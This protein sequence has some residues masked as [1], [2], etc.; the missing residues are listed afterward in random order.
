MLVLSRQIGEQIYIGDDVIV[1][2]IDIRGDKARIGVEAPKDIPVHRR[3]IAERISRER[4][5]RDD[6]CN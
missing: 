5:E 2:L 1:T 6:A 4:Q 3:E